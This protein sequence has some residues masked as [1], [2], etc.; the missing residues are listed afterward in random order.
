MAK[1]KISS[2]EI[3]ET[4]DKNIYKF[5]NHY[6]CVIEMGYDRVNDKFYDTVKLKYVFTRYYNRQHQ[7]YFNSTEEQVKEMMQEDGITVP[8][9]IDCY[10][11]EDGI[12]YTDTE[13]TTSVTEMLRAIN[14]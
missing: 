3:F 7:K 8:T 5:Y 11:G 2:F 4:P 12:L 6:Y 14:K 10:V 9:Y 1:R 13:F